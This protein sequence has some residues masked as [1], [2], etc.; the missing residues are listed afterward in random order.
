[1]QYHQLDVSKT[2]SIRAFCK[3]LKEK[4]VDGI[5]FVINNAGIARQGFG[6]LKAATAKS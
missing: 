3:V 6:A 2:N 1:M 4:H 5:D